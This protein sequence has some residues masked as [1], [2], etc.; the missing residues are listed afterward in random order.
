M[1][2]ARLKYTLLALIAL[3]VLG[4]DLLSVLAS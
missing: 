2:S 3:A 1:R 4:G